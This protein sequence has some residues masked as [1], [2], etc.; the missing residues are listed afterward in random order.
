MEVGG[1]TW[2]AGTG[3]DGTVR[4]T[5]WGRNPVCEVI[6]PKTL[7]FDIYIFNRCQCTVNINVCY[8]HLTLLFRFNG[9]KR[10]S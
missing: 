2:R 9:M 7:F 6:T 4:G 8:N 1:G 10:K 5:G 3:R